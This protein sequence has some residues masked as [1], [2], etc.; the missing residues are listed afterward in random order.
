MTRI[1]TR[2]VLVALAALTATAAAASADEIDRR[3][4]L[5]E[6]RIQQGARSGQLTGR[7]YRALEAEQARIRE[8]ERRAKADGYVSASERAQIRSAQDNASR[9]IRAEST[10]NER[11]GTFWRRWW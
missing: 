3:Q 9:H 6:Q 1:V 2:S 10:D 4:A 11:R 5:Q 7:E 8:L